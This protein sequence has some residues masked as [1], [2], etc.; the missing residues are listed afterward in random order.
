[1][2]T[3]IVTIVGQPNVGKSTLFNA[4]AG[5]RIAITSETAGTTRDRI[6]FKVSHPEMDFNIVDTGGLTFGKSENTIEEDMQAQARIAIDEADLIVFLVD[7]REEPNREDY[8]A[9]ELL[10]KKAAGK[11]VLLVASKCDKPMSEAELAPFYALGLGDIGTISAVH[12]SGI[13]ELVGQIVDRLKLRDFVTKKDPA[14]K[15]ALE[16]EHNHISI[17]MV[18]KPNVGKSSLINALLGKARHVVSEIPGTT[19]DSADSIVRH[20]GKDYNFIDTA[21]L[22]KRG[23]V[24]QGIEKWSDLR[25]LAAIDRCDV[26]ILV[27]DSAERISHQDKQIAHYI[28][29]AG[30][31]IIILANTWDINE[32][33]TPEEKRRDHFFATLRH[34]FAF[35]PFAPALFTSAVTKK[36]LSVIFSQIEDIYAQRKKRVA[37]AQLNQLVERIVEDHKPTGYGKAHP[38]LYYMTQVDIDPPQFVAFVNIKKSFHFSYWRYVENKLREKFGFTGTPIRIDCREKAPRKVMKK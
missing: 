27:I 32:E 15:K 23:K 36:N 29:E 37:T 1:M 13:D 2:K 33:E 16:W 18:G 6:F 8:N 5:A 14:Y 28:L 34:H 30:K 3:P 35:L 38:R 4:I 24:G 31:G 22:K 12:R 25:T 20:D 7:A 17:A 9:A 21:G 19:R 26:A 11:P 10:R